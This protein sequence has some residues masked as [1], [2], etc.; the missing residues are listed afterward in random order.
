MIADSI[1]DVQCHFIN[2]S[3]AQGCKILITSD[4][5]SVENS[6]TVLIKNSESNTIVSQ[7]L[8]L[9]YSIDCYHRVF[10]FDIEMN[11]TIGKSAIIERA[12][13]ENSLSTSHCPI[14]SA[15]GK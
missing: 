13:M 4:H 14:T 2:G 8:N 3:D 9:S 6:S 1:I 10:A 5:P 7:E 15:V 11:G 12:V